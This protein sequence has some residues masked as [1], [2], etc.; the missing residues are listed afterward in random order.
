MPV[1]TELVEV[2][3]SQ[4]SKGSLRQ[5]QAEQ[6]EAAEQGAQHNEPYTYG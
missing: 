1:R 4:V 6:V 5:A 3:P 2:L